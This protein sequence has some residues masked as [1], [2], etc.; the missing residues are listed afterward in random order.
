MVRIL[1]I[2]YNDMQRNSGFQG[3]FPQKFLH[4]LSL[5]RAYLLRRILSPVF[6]MRT[7][8]DIYNDLRKRLIHRHEYTGIALN[9][10][11]IS[12]RFAEGLTQA[13]PD[14]LHRMMVINLDIRTDSSFSI[15]NPDTAGR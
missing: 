6:K 13:D 9:A 1:S 3:Q 12:Q 11:F 4:Q 5:K 10:F 15:N 14:V 7:V 8:A 2:V